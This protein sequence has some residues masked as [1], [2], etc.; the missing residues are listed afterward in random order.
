MINRLS[1]NYNI[2]PAIMTDGMLWFKDL[3][4]PD[5][6]GILPVVGGII[7]LMNMM[8]TASAGGNSNFRKFAKVLRVFPL[9]SIPI[10]MITSPTNAP[11]K[12]DLHKVL[13]IVCIEH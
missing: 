4:S 3:S 9:I 12:L 1:Y 7:S 5:P 11:S 6:T 10:F 8:S 2:N 13:M